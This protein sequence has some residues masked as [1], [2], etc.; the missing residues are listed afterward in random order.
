MLDVLQIIL[1][2]MSVGWIIPTI[3]IVNQNQ[4][5]YPVIDET[6]TLCD[7]LIQISVLS[8]YSYKTIFLESM[9]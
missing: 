6:L 1:H 8:I 3:C 2:E 7:Y 9:N 4:Q 5:L